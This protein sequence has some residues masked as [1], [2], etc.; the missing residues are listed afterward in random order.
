MSWQPLC[1]W[2][3]MQ[4][5]HVS[6]SFVLWDSGIKHCQCVNYSSVGQPVILIPQAGSDIEQWNTESSLH[7]SKSL[8]DA[9]HMVLLLV[10]LFFFSLFSRCYP[11]STMDQVWSTRWATGDRIWKRTGRSTSLKDT[12]LWWRTLQLLCPMR[13]RSRL[14][15]IR[16]GVL[17]PELQLDTQERTVS[18][19]FFSLFVFSRYFYNIL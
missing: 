5:D 17:S 2:R 9:F 13:L 3:A 14:G 8:F 1:E 7:D 4:P 18:R 15:T 11:S 19:E 16:D 10:C 6:C 12:H